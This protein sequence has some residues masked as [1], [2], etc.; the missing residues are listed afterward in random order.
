MRAQANRLYRIGE[1][2]ADA[3]GAGRDRIPECF[4]FHFRK[5][6]S[7]ELRCITH[8]MLCQNLTVGRKYER[9]A[10]A[11]SDVEGQ[12]THFRMLPGSEFTS[13]MTR[14]SGHTNFLTRWLSWRSPG[15]A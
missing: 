7:R 15:A 1:I 14:S 10:C 6:R 12:Q 13:P 3:S 4:G 8:G 5:S 11:R 9:L 2:L